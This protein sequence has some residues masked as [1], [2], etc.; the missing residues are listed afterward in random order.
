VISAC[1][2]AWTLDRAVAQ[3][4]PNRP[5]RLVVPLVAGSPGDI[6]ARLVGD[7][8]SKTLKQPIVVEN[9]PGAAGNIGTEFIAKSAPDGY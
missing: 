4:Y 2:A 6:V 8:L 9:R 1:I 5:I 7:K 3:T